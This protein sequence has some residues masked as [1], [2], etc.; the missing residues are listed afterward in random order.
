MDNNPKQIARAAG[1]MYLVVTVG[2]ILGLMY[3]PSQFI[4]RGDALATAGN[5]QTHALLF[6]SW[7]ASDLIT[8][9]VFL[10]LPFALY[11]LFEGVNRKWA[12]VM[13]VLAV[14]SVPLGFASMIDRLDVLT[15]LGDAQHLKAFTTEQLHSQMML[16]FRNADHATTVAELFWGLW[17][18][19]FGYLVFRSGFIPRLLGVLLMVNGLAYVALCLIGLLAPDYSGVAFRVAFP[20][21]FGEMLIMLWLLIVGVRLPA[22]GIG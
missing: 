19:P 20:A 2:G 16:A 9:T 11:R 18:L 6:R 5:I 1:A 4:V 12:T 10:L 14:A 21:F 8:G 3:F 15:L 13:V 17:L 22:H 7:I